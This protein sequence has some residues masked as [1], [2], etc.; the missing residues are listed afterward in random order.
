[1]HTASQLSTSQFSVEIDG[2]PAHPAEVLSDWN[3]LDRF[4][5]IATTAHGI[6]GASLLIQLATALYY[7][8]RAADA[9]GYPEIYA[10]HVG[11]THGHHSAFDFYPDRKEVVVADDLGSV[12]AAINDRGITRLAVA[13]GALA[14]VEVDWHE[15]EAARER[16]VTLLA[17]APS[18]RVREPDVVIAARSTAVEHNTA[19]TLYADSWP[20][21]V[22]AMSDAEL[23]R[24]ELDPD[25]PAHAVVHYSR[26]LAAEQPRY[27]GSPAR[28]ARRWATSAAARAGDVAPEA[29]R[30]LK[31]QRG[32]VLRG[33][34]PTES[35]ARIDLAQALDLLT[36]GERSGGV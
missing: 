15:L 18:G 1:M 35:Y 23:Q 26:A 11:C 32:R 30:A 33:G 4:G 24:G 25:D 20:E 16:L 31:E 9:D 3:A 7:A 10:F 8:A 6:V 2:M 21:R 17:Y 12:V 27:G 34:L 5:V 22:L 29:R 13:P 14:P 36:H 28:I 19:I